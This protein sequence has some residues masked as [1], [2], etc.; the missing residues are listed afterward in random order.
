MKAVT[1]SIRTTLISTAIT[2]I[3]LFGAAPVAAYTPPSNDDAAW[4]YKP[5]TV[6]MV[7]LQLPQ[8]SIDALWADAR[9]YVPGTPPEVGAS[10]HG[11]LRCD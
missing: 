5:S 11:P 1:T 7:N 4:L 9:T 10:A 2:I 6:A 3:M 8:S